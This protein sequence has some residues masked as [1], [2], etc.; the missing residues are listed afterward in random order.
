MHVLSVYLFGA[1]ISI[2]AA[3]FLETLAIT[4]PL[5]LRSIFSSGFW[6]YEPYDLNLEIVILAVV[7]APLVEEWTKGWAS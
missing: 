5:Q 2:I 6:S 7:I 4:C 3:M 1:I